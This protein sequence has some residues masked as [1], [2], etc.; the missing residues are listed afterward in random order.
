MYLS[1]YPYISIYLYLYSTYNLLFKLTRVL[2]VSD[3]GPNTSGIEYPARLQ[4]PEYVT[5][6]CSSPIIDA[7]CFSFP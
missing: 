5:G 1:L 4:G 2:A 7:I 6:V 3:I